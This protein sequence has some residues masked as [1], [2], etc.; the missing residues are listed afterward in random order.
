MMPDYS[1]TSSVV[2]VV[3][4]VVITCEVTRLRCCV[5][6]QARHSSVAPGRYK[7]ECLENGAFRAVAF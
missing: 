6:A 3:A 5:I 7:H 2:V 1:T 4:I